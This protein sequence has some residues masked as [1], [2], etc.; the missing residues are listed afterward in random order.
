MKRLMFVLVALLLIPFGAYVRAESMSVEAVVVDSAIYTF[1]PNEG[2]A[3]LDRLMSLQDPDIKR[4]VN[5]QRE[6]RSLFIDV[7]TNADGLR[8][9]R[10]HIKKNV[11]MSEERNVTGATTLEM[12]G[13][14]MS[15]VYGISTN[16][17]KD[18]GT[19]YRYFKFYLVKFVIVR[20]QQDRTGSNDTTI[21]VID[22]TR[23]YVVSPP[24]FGGMTVS[25]STA[26]QAHGVLCVGARFNLRPNLVADAKIGHSILAN[27]RDVNDGTSV[28]AYGMLYHASVTYILAQRQEHRIAIDV[29]DSTG[30]DTSLVTTINHDE[31]VTCWRVGI[32]F[33]VTQVENDTKST[34]DYLI[35][36]RVAEIGLAYE[37]RSIGVRG[38]VGYGWDEHYYQPEVDYKATG[39][40][41]LVVTL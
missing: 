8:Y 33:G 41:E 22:S 5:R 12:Y 34:F 24:L 13:A 26:P 7:K 16:V 11:L 28:D 37:Y 25:L 38:L 2:M 4:L 39:R 3:A 21:V 1:A 30:G 6:D 18:I 19:K 20:P 15:R 32:V 40:L 29:V 10:D 27:T 17:E 9:R 23:H 36:R 14:D 31:V 35:K